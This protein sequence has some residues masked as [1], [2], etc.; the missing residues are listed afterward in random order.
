MKVTLNVFLLITILFA[1]GNL[2]PLA[3]GGT[4]R[5]AVPTDLT[6]LDLHKTTAQIDNW[7]LGSA[8]FEKLF[9]Y[10]QNLNIKPQ[11]AE[12]YT[13]SSD[14]L[15]II[16]DLRKGVLFHDSSEMTADDVKFSIERVMS[17]EL[18]VFILQIL[19]V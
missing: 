16:I 18:P 6:N 19:I 3:I 4:L 9:S 12:K 17:K 10:D 8:V 2:P 14:G 1:F 7:L 15:A 5:V 11:L 13:I